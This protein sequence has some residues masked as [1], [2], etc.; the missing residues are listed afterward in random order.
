MII[1]GISN[2]CHTKITISW[3]KFPLQ[4]F[5]DT[6]YK[7]KMYKKTLNDLYIT[8][9]DTNAYIR[10]FHRLIRKKFSEI[11]LHLCVCAP[12][13]GFKTV[14]CKEFRTSLCIFRRHIDTYY[15]ILYYKNY[16]LKSVSLTFKFCSRSINRH[17]KT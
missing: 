1:D 16:A 3:W 13:I 9:A 14:H 5:F 10:I 11:W 2:T 7:F 15:I 6:I 17:G 8:P 12:R 4:N